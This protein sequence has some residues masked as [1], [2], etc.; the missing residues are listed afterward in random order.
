ML[1]IFLCDDEPAILKAV[2]EA[3]KAEGHRVTCAADGLDAQ[4][5]LEGRTFDV[6]ICDVRLPNVDGLTLFNQVRQTAPETS[7]IMMTA[8]A[9]VPDAVGAV[10]HGAV[11]YL[12]KPFDLDDLLRTLQR[13]EQEQQLSKQLADVTKT[14]PANGLIGESHV[15]RRLRE[16]V[17][18]FAQA[19]A[20][21]LITGESGSGKEVVA[22]ALHAASPRAAEPFMAVNCASLP[23]TLIEA[24]LFGHERGAFT[25]A[26]KRREGRFKAAGAG[27]LMLDEVGELPLPAQAK[28]LRVL[29]EGTFEPLGTNRT[30]RSKARVISATNR[31][32]KMM[33]EKKL[34]REDLF[35]RLKILEIGVP[36]LRDRPGDLVMLVAHILNQLCAGQPAPPL[37]GR[38]LAA[39]SGYRFPG[40][41]RELQHALE[42]ARVLSGG[43]AIDIG[44][45][46]RE[47]AGEQELEPRT[48]D[49]ALRPLPE[50]VRSFE[51]EYLKRALTE[52]RGKR[53]AAAAMLGIS[54]KSLWE[55]LCIY[56]V[57]EA[58]L[59]ACSNPALAAELQKADG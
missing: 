1:Q 58:E 3:L 43:G 12:A 46:P 11:D 57:T 54:R 52:V 23:D 27:T 53:G 44:H 21:V 31:D 48:E 19:D 51:R 47:I 41:V 5:I 56:G 7:C 45:L 34:F 36:S 26:V 22:R 37:T 16:H 32:L 42:Y 13:I 35:Y 59:E 20:P 29:Q 18:R 4:R 15:M 28:L 25:G 50:A 39:L 24:E 49:R 17:E 8:Y 14:G 33:V 2:E 6:V 38:A 40:N 30:E 55:K 10:K 9:T